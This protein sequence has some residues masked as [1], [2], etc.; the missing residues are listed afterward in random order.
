MKKRIVLFVVMAVITSLAMGRT[1]V[2]APY[3]SNGTPPIDVSGSSDFPAGVLCSFPVNVT[4]TGKFKEVILP[5]GRTKLSFPGH[6]STITNLASPTNQLT[7]H[8]GGSWHVTQTATGVV[9]KLTG[10]N[11]W[12]GSQ[13]GFVFATGNFTAVEDANGNELQPISGHGTLISDVCAM[14]S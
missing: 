10:R 8:D 5:G 2:A 11:F 7:L 14:I 13:S 1:S 9:Y 3:R 12:V 6:I 4:G